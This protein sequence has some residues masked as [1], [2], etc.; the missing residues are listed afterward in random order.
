MAE[1][2]EIRS[3]FD[4]GVKKLIGKTIMKK[5]IGKRIADSEEVDFNNDNE[6]ADS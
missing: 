1:K 4:L 3:K 5:M 6:E 2:Y